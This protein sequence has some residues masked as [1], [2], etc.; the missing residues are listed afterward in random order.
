VF[1][2]VRWDALRTWGSTGDTRDPLAAEKDE[3][4]V[5][6]AS[7]HV[8]AAQSQSHALTDIDTFQ[9]GLSSSVNQSGK[10]GITSNVSTFSGD[11]PLGDDMSTALSLPILQS[12][13][14]SWLREVSD[15]HNVCADKLLGNLYRFVSSRE[16][17]LSDPALHR[18]V[19][20]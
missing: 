11:S 14:Q 13:I 8:V 7:G 12:L 9:V 16:S 6:A 10:P 15:R 17:F 20:S 18:V 5:H 19:L 3:S 1:L 2:N 4:H